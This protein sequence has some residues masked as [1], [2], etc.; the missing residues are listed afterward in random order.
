MLRFRVTRPTIGLREASIVLTTN[1]AKARER[2]LKIVIPGLN[3]VPFVVQAGL[4]KVSFLNVTRNGHVK[5]VAI[6]TVEA[7]NTDPWIASWMSSA[8]YVSANLIDISNSPIE[9]DA[10]LLNRTYTFDLVLEG[11]PPRGTH[12]STIAL[13]DRTRT[14]QVA[15]IAVLVNRVAPCYAVPSALFLEAGRSVRI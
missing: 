15:N 2:R 11:L 4:E 12:L 10:R 7:S 9:E 8:G 13:M 5:T 6:R 3:K 14:N 1:D